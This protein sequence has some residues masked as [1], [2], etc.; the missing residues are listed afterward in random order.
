MLSIMKHHGD[1]ATCT[2]SQEIK[3]KALQ[4]NSGQQGN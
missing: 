1:G 4:I 3:S 2:L